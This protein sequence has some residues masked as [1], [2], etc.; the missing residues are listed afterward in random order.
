M[1]RLHPSGARKRLGVS[2]LEYIFFAAVILIAVAVAANAPA[3]A[4]VNEAQEVRREIETTCAS[5]AKPKPRGMTGWE[6]F[7]RFMILRLIFR[8]RLNQSG[9]AKSET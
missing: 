9:T 1:Q 7:P 8:R 2:L 3:V 5:R 6:A 4:I